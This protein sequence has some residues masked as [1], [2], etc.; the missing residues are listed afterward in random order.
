MKIKKFQIESCPYCGEAD[1]RVGIQSGQATLDCGYP[2]FLDT[3][4]PLKHLICGC[5]GAVL[6]SWVETPGKFISAEKYFDR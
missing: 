6:Y 1:F 2:E 5:C 4:S 3:M